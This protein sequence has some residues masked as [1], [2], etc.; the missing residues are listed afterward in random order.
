MPLNTETYH[1][2][3]E[4]MFAIQLAVGDIPQA[5][6]SGDAKQITFTS[7]SGATVGNGETTRTNQATSEVT[8][9]LMS[10]YLTQLRE[11]NSSL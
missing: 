9:K 10:E 6:K 2:K 5:S 11:R 1:K 3:N 8:Q 4:E 7:R